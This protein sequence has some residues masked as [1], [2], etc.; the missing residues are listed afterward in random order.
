V[1]HFLLGRL[2]ACVDLLVGC[3]RLPEAAFFA[4]TYAPSRVAEVVKLWQADLAKINPKAAESLA[5]PEVRGCPIRR[6]DQLLCLLVVCVCVC[7]GGGRARARAL[8]GIREGAVHL[9]A[10]AGKRRESRAPGERPLLAPSPPV[11]H[12]IAA[13]FHFCCAGVPQPLPGH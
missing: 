9:G 5:N 2:D 13:L 8:V 1:C 12:P 6:I 10:T 11:H 4:R 3:G 7:V